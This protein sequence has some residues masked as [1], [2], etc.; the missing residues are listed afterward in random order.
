V[1]VR[2]DHA[3]IAVRDLGEASERYR[4]LGFSVE[5]GGRHT[6]K[7]TANA[8]IRFGL[9]YV[10]LLAVDDRAEALAGGPNRV[11]L[12][13]FLD[14]RIAGMTTFALAEHDLEGPADALRAL[15][16]ATPEPAAAERR[17][18]DG[19]VLR[20]RTLVP[21]GSS[22]GQ[23]WPFLIDWPAGGM[24]GDVAPVHHANGATGVAGVTVQAR[25]RMA[26]EVYRALGVELA[27][28]P[29]GAG[30][31][32]GR[33]GPAVLS[34]VVGDDV[35]VGPRELA[36]RVTDLPTFERFVL[37]TGRRTEA[38][39]GTRNRLRIADAPPELAML[40]FTDQEIEA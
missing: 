31:W 35:G 24:A 2:F 34:V 30:A 16:V 18:L 25:D 19:T 38:A 6:G 20:W 12:V 5:P 28:S 4:A 15:G 3:V 40:T 39:P 29:L 8:L 11:A 37:E 14:A 33:I 21:G 27:P 10:E 1:S 36:I 17:R 23:A 7:G 13:E 9:D 26:I 22:V 32:S